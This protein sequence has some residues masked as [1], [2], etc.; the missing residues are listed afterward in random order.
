MRNEE[1]LSSYSSLDQIPPHP[2]PLFS[3]STL[4]HSAVWHKSEHSSHQPLFES[5]RAYVLLY[6]WTTGSSG[7]WGSSQLITGVL[8]CVE[9]RNCTGLF[10]LRHK[11]LCKV[12]HYCCDPCHCPVC[13]FCIMFSPRLFAPHGPFCGKGEDPLARLVQ[14][15]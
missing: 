13:V 3:S 5:L 8:I 9:P 11:L 15:Q 10:L 14:P 1:R 2:A 7:E 6:G 12:T 4:F